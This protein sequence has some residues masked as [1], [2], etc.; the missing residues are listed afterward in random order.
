MNKIFKD[1]D[2]FLL[3]PSEWN[4]E[5]AEVIAK[6]FDDTLNEEHWIVIKYIRSYFDQHQ[7]VP[8][9]RHL[10]KDFKNSYGIEK[11]T[12]KYINERGE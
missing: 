1:S 5:V 3:D 10:L 12:R 2:G 7:K 11:S 4:Q 8:E 9:L 6:E